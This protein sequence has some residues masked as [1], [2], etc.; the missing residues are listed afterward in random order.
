MSGASC[1]SSSDR[2][3]QNPSSS[4]GLSAEFSGAGEEDCAAAARSWCDEGKLLIP[5]LPNDLA[6]LCIARLPRGMFPLLRLVSSAWKRAVSSETFRLLRHQGGF[7]QGWIYVLVES[8][9]GAA[10]RAFDPD[11]NRWYNMSPVP[12]NISSETWQGFACVA[13]DSKL[14]LMGGARRI[15]NEATQQLG[16]VEVCGDVFIYDAFRNKWQRGP[17][18]TTPRGWFAAAAIGDFVYVA[19][20]QGR[21]CF[22]DSAEVL[23]YRE[24]RWHQMPSM[25]CVRSSCRGTVL[26]GQ[27]WVIA[28]EV[29]INNYG[30]HPQRASAEFFNP[31][32]KSWTLIPEMWLDSHKVPGPN[33]IFRENLLVVHQSKLMRYDPE[34]NE[35]DHIGHIS[36]G[37][38]YNRSSYRFGF[39]LECLGDKLYVIG[40]RIESW[41]NRNRSSIQPVSTAEV[42]HLGTASNSKFTRWN[43]V[44]DMK[45]SSGIIL[46]SATVLL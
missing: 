5:G 17:S 32:S 34:L 15:Y 46:A 3:G 24:K 28:G 30:D 14:I 38:L 37:K 23:D 12:A 45:D 33:T 6:I 20:G 44:A 42:C 43:S 31:A 40:G 21:S 2:R 1:S 29:V 16:Q 10:F 26:N 7:L 22:L 39:A 36:T 25:H 19:G 18:L 41:Q 27:F 4:V 35:W 9:T 8:A 13:L 11:A